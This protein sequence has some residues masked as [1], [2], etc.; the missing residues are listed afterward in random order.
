MA[1]TQVEKKQGAGG[2]RETYEVKSVERDMQLNKY[3]V[4]EGLPKRYLR[5]ELLLINK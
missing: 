4:L 2:V 3:Y 5:H 1:I